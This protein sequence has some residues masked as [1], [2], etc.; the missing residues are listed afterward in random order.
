MTEGN[1]GIIACPILE[2][3]MVYNL[4]NDKELGTVLLLDNLYSK[5]VR[6]KLERNGVKYSLC[7]EEGFLNGS[8]KL[9]DK[10][11]NVAIWMMDLGLHEEPTNLK[12]FVKNSANRMQNSVDAI[13]LYYGLCG[14]ALK[15][16]DKWKDEGLRIPI[17]IIRD[18]DGNTCDDCI[19]VAV[20]GTRNY[21]RL[22]RKHPG[23]MYFT[24][25][26]A[27]NF[28][29]LKGRMELFRGMGTDDDSQLKMVFEMADYHYV[30]EIP[31]GLG[32]EKEFHEATKKFAERM[33]FDIMYLDKEWCTLEPIERS[34]AGAK[35][36]LSH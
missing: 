36:L 26:F 12:D 31:T 33:D 7:S 14:N 32:D 3:E 21:L 19:A 6:P 34:Y 2:E 18:R 24:P 1:L 16:I 23:I 27:T 30:M 11:Y 17:T 10:G 25:A 9:P 29:D 8:S 20:G 15:D 4:S 5:S 28:D 35:G 22:L 13:I